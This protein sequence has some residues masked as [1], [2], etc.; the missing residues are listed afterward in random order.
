MTP[1]SKSPTRRIRRIQ[2][3]VSEW[4]S[5]V[6]DN[7]T[8]ANRRE[9]L[10]AVELAWLCSYALRITTEHGQATSRA[11]EATLALVWITGRLADVSPGIAQR[12][13]PSTVAH[14]TIAAFDE[15]VRLRRERTTEKSSVVAVADDET[16]E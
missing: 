13:T 9:K 8:L 16:S 7:W 12:S 14:A 2:R 3:Y 10:F 15:L 4:G 1:I 6:I 5:R 11:G